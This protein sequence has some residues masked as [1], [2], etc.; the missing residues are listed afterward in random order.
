MVDDI[1]SCINTPND[2]NCVDRAVAKNDPNEKMIT[3]EYNAI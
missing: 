2:P 3:Q 1:L